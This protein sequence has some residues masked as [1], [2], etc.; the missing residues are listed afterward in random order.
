M[1]DHVRLATLLAK[2]FINIFAFTTCFSLW[3]LLTVILLL[4]LV[5]NPRPFNV[6]S[7]QIYHNIGP[8]NLPFSQQPVRSEKY[9]LNMA[10]A[11]Q[12]R[13]RS[14]NVFNTRLRRSALKIIQ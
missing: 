5:V 14:G 10:E 4:L 9:I 2:A 11:T 8:L 6:F 13:R 1:Q 12:G 3:F 7:C